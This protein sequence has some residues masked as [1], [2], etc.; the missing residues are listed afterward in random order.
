MIF[1]PCYFL[2]ENH[3]T[4]RHM[5][6][7]GIHLAP[8]PVLTNGLFQ[9]ETGQLAL[10]AWTKH[11]CCPYPQNKPDFNTEQCASVSLIEQIYFILFLRQGLA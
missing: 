2:L 11:S 1:F 7:E 6:T 5:V 8:V 10:T 3:S 4:M 9:R